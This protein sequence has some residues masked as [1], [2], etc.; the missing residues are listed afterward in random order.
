[1]KTVFIWPILEIGQVTSRPKI[2]IQVKEVD[3][4]AVD[5]R[6]YGEMREIYDGPYKNQQII[7]MKREEMDEDF[8]D[9][10]LN[11]YIAVPSNHCE[12]K[13]NF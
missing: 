13:R 6:I 1:L 4:A 2:D 11:S 9:L 10:L 3:E 8:S 12:N 5:L 7:N